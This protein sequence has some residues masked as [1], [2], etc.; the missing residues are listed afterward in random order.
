MRNYVSLL[1]GAFFVLIFMP[2]CKK[3]D[4]T[5]NNNGAS[6]PLVDESTGWKRVATIQNTYNYI[7]QN[8]T[9]RMQGYDLVLSG[10]NLNVLYSEDKFEN[11]QYQ[12][13]FL[14]GAY[15]IGSSTSPVISVL[16]G[17]PYLPNN[18]NLVFR[19][20]LNRVSLQR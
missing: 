2:A 13:Q 14:K 10:N 11:G 16:P 15:T 18:P 4:P 9:C 5:N 1:A 6:S 8:T 7:D 12:S 19:P 3:T 20:V 17:E